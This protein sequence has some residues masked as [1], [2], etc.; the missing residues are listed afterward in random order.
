MID[1][2]FLSD[3]LLPSCMNVLI[4]LKSLYGICQTTSFCAES[5]AAGEQEL[6]EGASK[7]KGNEKI[8]CRNMTRGVVNYH[9]LLGRDGAAVNLTRSTLRHVERHSRSRKAAGSL[10]R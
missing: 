5:P 9:W 8:N 2:V 6:M 10:T 7:E 3:L 1:F 4:K